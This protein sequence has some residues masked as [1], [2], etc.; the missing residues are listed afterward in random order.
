MRAH[1]N[2]PRRIGFEN[3]QSR[4]LAETENRRARLR[5]LAEPF[6]EHMN[7]WRAS[8]MGLIDD[9]IDPAETRPRVIHALEALR[10]QKRGA[11]K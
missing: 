6:R 3:S 5:E 8:R 1:R 7:P 2:T 9:I 11:R 10:R 4:E